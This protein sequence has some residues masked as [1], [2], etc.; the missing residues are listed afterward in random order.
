MKLLGAVFLLAFLIVNVCAKHSIPL[1]F[2]PASREQRRNA[3]QYLQRKY[4]NN[5]APNTTI[6]PLSDVSDAQYFGPISIGTPHQNFEVVFDTGSSNLWVPSTHCRALACLD[7]KRYNSEKSSTYV[8]NGTAFAI[9]YGSGSLTGIV[10]SDVVSIGGLA[11]HNQSFAEAVTLP[12]LTFLVGRFDG[13]LGLAFDTISVDHIVP[14]WY[15]LLS[16]GLV[17]EP[18]FSVWL[19]KDPNGASGGS[20]ILGGTSDTY[21][22]GEIS[23]VKLTAKTYWQFSMDD[24]LVGG[25]TQSFCNGSCE[26]IADTGTSLIAGPSKSVTA[27]NHMLGAINFIKGEAIFPSCARALAGPN[28]TVVLDSKQYHL[29][30]KDYVIQSNNTCIS[31][32]LGIDIPGLSLWILG[33]VFISSYY[34]VFD[35]GNERVGFATAVQK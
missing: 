9:Q 4:Y 17:D 10:S 1:G 12:G 3:R 5:F 19:S 32:F 16:Q 13:I 23:Y 33:D 31:G 24:L 2:R 15:N 28:V 6:I 30:P 21:Y 29:T 35:F 22:T 7:H 8:K 26:V 18:L 27:L 11:I 20:L 14:P 25:K 34:T